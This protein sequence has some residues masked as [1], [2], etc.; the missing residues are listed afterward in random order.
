MI[1]DTRPIRNIEDILDLNI[2]NL[3]QYGGASGQF[4][5]L[6]S[7]NS[8]FSSDNHNVPIVATATTILLDDYDKAPVRKDF[9]D[10]SH[11]GGHVTTARKYW[12]WFRWK[13]PNS[14]LAFNDE[15]DFWGEFDDG[16]CFWGD[17]GQTSLNAFA[18]IQK[19]M[20]AN[21]L[22]I[23]VWDDS[24]QQTIIET[25]VDIRQAWTNQL[26]QSVD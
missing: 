11:P 2:I 4:R 5:L 14:K 15:P 12:N 8:W 20:G 23:T 21:D 9:P 7:I 25:H 16:H 1:I 24:G 17:I 10:W 13:Q 18:K 3:R 6:R 26:A 22:W 19:Q